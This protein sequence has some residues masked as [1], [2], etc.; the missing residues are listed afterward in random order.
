MSIY[1]Q[2]NGK[3]RAR[4]QLVGTTT[5]LGEFSTVEEA[6][7][8]DLAA[9]RIK[10]ALGNR[11]DNLFQKVIKRVVSGTGDCGKGFKECETVSDGVQLIAESEVRHESLDG[12]CCSRENGVVP[13]GGAG[14]DSKR[15]AEG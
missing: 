14:L 9:K 10:K 3:Y 4:V 7:A 15:S 6:N 5:Y 12:R 2:S 13:G 1:K 11:L 8:A